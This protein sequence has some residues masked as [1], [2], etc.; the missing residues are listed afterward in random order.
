MDHRRTTRRSGWASLVVVALAACAA[1]Q[2]LPSSPAASTR[3]SPTAPADSGAPDPGLADGDRL[4]RFLS[5]LQDVADA[6]DGIRA[7]GT[8]GYNA[9]ADL[10]AAELRALGLTVETPE[11]PFTSFR[12]VGATLDVGGRSFTGPDEARALIYSPSGD[13]AGPVVVLDGSGCAPEDF[14]GVQPGAIA[15]TLEGGCLRRDQALNAS[16]AGVAALVVGYPGRGPGEIFRPTLID[17]SG[18]DV[19]VISVTDEAV[20]AL[21]DAEGSMARV[22]ADTEIAASTLRNVITQAGDGPRVV[23]VGAHLDS[24]FDGPGINDNGSGVAAVLEVARIV[25]EVGVPDGWAVRIGL[26]GGEELGTVG[27]RAYA[28]DLVPD[29]LVAYLNLDMAGSVNGST[30]VYDEATAAVGSD[31]ITE[32]YEAWLADRGEPSERID[33]GG[34]SDHYGFA[35]AGIPTGGLFAGAAAA[36]SAS[37]PSSSPVGPAPDPCYHIGCDDLDNVDIDRVALF[38]DATVAVVRRLMEDG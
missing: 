34:S 15:V 6:N 30:L 29:E 27:S 21:R 3:V 8:P 20:E 37:N 31:R 28:E 2:P 25:A 12:D 1:T 32:A 38:A 5:E 10:V 18:I 7:S 4:V 11:V 35:L 9:S 36:G 24:V 33:I 14:T 16:E 13:V 17:P 22:V 19:P 23:M 26:W